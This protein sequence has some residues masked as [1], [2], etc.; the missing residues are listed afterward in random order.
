MNKIALFVAIPAFWI[1]SLI[2]VYFL[3][4]GTQAP[5]IP[6]PKAPTAKQSVEPVVL[7]EWAAS[8]K[9]WSENFA[10]GDGAEVGE[11]SSLTVSREQANGGT[12][13]VNDGEGIASRRELTFRDI[14]QTFASALRSDDFI[15]RNRIT[16]EMLASVTAEN[17]RDFLQT[18]KDAP[19]DYHTDGNYRMFLH[20]WARIDGAAAMDY[21]LHEDEARQVGHGRTWAMAGWAQANPEA[22]FAYME[23]LENP[24]QQRELY[25]GFA[26]GWTRTDLDGAANHIA[27]L[28]DKG[29]RKELVGVLAERHMEYRG[30]GGAL[31]WVTKIAQTTEDKEY[32]RDVFNHTIKKT[33]ADNGIEVA[34][35]IDRNPDNENI[36]DW[37][38]EEA[39]DEWAE[40]N[41][42]AAANWLESHM[43]DERVT[44]KVIAEFTDEWAKTDGPAAA[45][46]AD[47]YRGTT[48]FDDKV[49]G[50][51]AGEWAENDPGG[52]LDW[53]DTL[54]GSHQRS[55]YGYIARQWDDKEQAAE[56]VRSV[57]ASPA[58]DEARSGLA[59]RL[60]KD[61]P[62]QALEHAGQITDK[63]MRERS[64]VYAAQVL[65]RKNPDAVTAW[66]PVSGLSDGAIQK[67][68]KPQDRR[69]R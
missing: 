60:A 20:A 34:Q 37:V 69:R 29:L 17:A 9:E 58:M 59:S 47:D 27:S 26:R 30:R 16:A 57:P 50:R 44:G 54:E 42:V 33:V 25:Q 65:Y 22:A 66:L 5:D 13:R 24:K 41:P 6:Q 12:R 68:V 3:A 64:L 38:F 31:D 28:E 15:E 52:A 62:V 1:A 2:V 18:F 4:T 56:W 61:D 36:K 14:N 23:G 63:A 51:L 7:R 46:W 53:A 40:S 32:A 8:P 10:N 21:L 67:V 35:W 11:L 45:R 19:K 39:A 43:E 48:W 55:A 49:A